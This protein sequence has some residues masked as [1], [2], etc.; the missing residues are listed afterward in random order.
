MPKRPKYSY[1][2]DIEAAG[3]VR[4]RMT[5]KRRQE[6][7]TFPPPVD[8]GPNTRAWIDE[9]LDEVDRRVREGITT[10]NADWLRR[11]AE[12]RARAAE[13]DQAAA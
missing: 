10:P 4:N 6:A 7:G 11:L 9:D 13:R 1:Y 5:L 2:P 3:Y 8:L 12:R